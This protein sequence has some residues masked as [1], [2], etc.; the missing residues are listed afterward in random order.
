MDPVFFELD[1]QGFKVEAPEP[2][3]PLLLN[4]EDS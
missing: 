1:V 3:S 2:F 4:V